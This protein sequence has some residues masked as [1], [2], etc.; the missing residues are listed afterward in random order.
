[1]R[2]TTDACIDQAARHGPSMS[3]GC[4]E[5]TW[6]YIQPYLEKWAAKTKDGEPCVM[7]IGP[8]GCGHCEYCDREPNTWLIDQTSR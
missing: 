2:E 1:M 7:R 8:G 5:K 6:K 3:P 4:S